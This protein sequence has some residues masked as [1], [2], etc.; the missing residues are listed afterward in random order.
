V[1]S[2]GY[3]KASGNSQDSVETVTQ[4]GSSV[5]S[6]NGNT[7]IQA[8][9]ALSV[10]A[11]DISAGNNLTLIGKSVDLSAA[12]NTSVEHGAQQSSSSG[13]SVGVTFNPLAAFKSAYQQSASGNPSTS[14]MGRASKYGDAIGDGALAASTPVVVQAGSRSASGSQDHATSSAQVSSLTA[15]NNLTV[16]AT[17][18]SI[19]SQGASMSAGGDATLIAKDS[20]NLDVAH[21]FETQGQTNTAKGWSTDNRGSL[22]VG[23]FNSKGNGN[24]STDTIRGTSLSAGGKAMLATTDGDISL[25]AANLVANSDLS[26]NAA[27]NLTIQSGQDTLTNA[28]QNNSQAIGKVV[29]SDT[30]RFAG[31]HSEKSKDNNTAI[32]QV[33]SN[34][35]SLQG[36]VSLSAGDKYTQT[37]SNVLAKNDINIVAKSIDI[38]TAVNTGSSD[39]SSADLKIGAFARVTSPLIDLGNNIENARKSDGRLQAMQG[40]AAAS[41]G[42]QVASAVNALR[43]GAGSGE[44][45]KAEVGVGFATANSQDRSNY[46]QAQG[47]SVLGGGNVNLTSTEG[48]IHATGAHIAAG[49]AAGKTLTLDSARN[50]LLDAGQ[51]T[52]TS[53]GSNHSAG[54]EVGVGYEVGA[55]TGAYIYATANVGNG[56][57][58]NSATTNSNTQLS[59]DTVTL[60]SK[61][62][63]TLKGATVKANTIN[64]DVGGKLAIESV[65][66]TSVQHNEQSSVGGRVQ[67]SIGTAWEASGNVGQST[68]NGSSNAVNQQSGLFA[69]NGGYHVTADTVALKGG[70]IAS[71]NAANS[72]LTAKS[73]TFENLTNKMDYSASTVSMSGGYGEKTGDASTQTGNQGNAPTQTSTG[74]S[75]PNVTPGIP[76][77]ESGSASSTTYGT[78]TDGKITIGGQHMTSAAGLGAHTDL[79]TAHTAIAPLPD[80]K[81]VMANQQAMAAAANTVIATGAQIA[82]DLGTAANKKNEQAQ[83]VLNNKDSTQAQKE[84]AQQ[85]ANDA[86]A[87]IKNWGPTGDYTRALKVVT[88]ILV[89]GVAGEGVGQ[90]AANASAPYAAQAI[91]DYFA[92]PGHD[93]QTVQLLTHAVLGGILAAANGGSALAGAGAGAAGE[94]AAKEITRQLYPN[95]FDPDGSFHPEKLDANQINTVISLSTAVGALVAGA[96]GGSLLDASVGGNIAANAATYNRLLSHA[97][98]QLIKDKAGINIAEADRLTKAACY[99]LKCWAQY[100]EG[101]K[102]YNDNYVSVMDAYDLKN[103][104]AWIKSQQAQGQFVYSAMNDIMDHARSTDVPIALNGL[105]VATG[106]GTATAGIALCGTGIGCA[107]GSMMIAFGS[108]NMMEGGNALYNAYLGNPAVGVNPLRYGFNQVFPVWGNTLYDGANL[109]VTL[110]SLAVPVPRMVGASD[111]IDRAQS[112]FG[113]TTSGFNNLKMLPFSNLPYP[114]GVNQAIMIFGVGAQAVTVTNDVLGAGKKK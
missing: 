89:G 107:P 40:L 91:G 34:V 77:M 68:A 35:G 2:I 71:S 10:V 81:N 59:G 64:A 42:Y 63:T 28:N 108:S 9:Q 54:V 4:Q 113:S 27:R 50:I 88:G 24:G 86:Q 20:I 5:A 14:F 48:D 106:W 41:N 97:E 36:N 29:I 76:L 104:I 83:A 90:L 25:T 60:A 6:I 80:L 26:I 38:N 1:A 110:G 102:G 96:T 8:G 75:N 84:Q 111:G 12:Q 31:Y 58:N 101:S 37:A 3:S 79:A 66:D 69:G 82:N 46:S 56:N 32:T 57:Y 72:E 51:S 95:A 55:K 67:V 61:G 100:P 7:R 52:A 43:G 44:L 73:I 49:D 94:L 39:Q 78:L 11:S 15:G 45:L 112:L 47:S 93:N 62:D 13:L 70:A 109:A 18:G 22:P 114:Y 30:E 85:D 98:K 65:Q 23:V 74:A 105:K 16:L 103:E 53:S 19:T 21:S 17:G 92:Q 87:A 99:E 33:A